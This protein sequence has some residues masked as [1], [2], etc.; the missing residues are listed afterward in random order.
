MF[1][2]KKEHN[3]PHFHAYYQDYKGTFD[4]TTGEMIEG[5]LPIRQIRLVTAWAE[6]HKEELL[7]DWQLSQ[8]GEKP[9]T[10]EPLR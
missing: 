7:A 4:I 9:Y 1:L 2:G 5:N 3:P 8:S 6:L 10:I